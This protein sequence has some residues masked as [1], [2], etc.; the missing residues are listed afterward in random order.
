MIID[1]TIFYDF[2]QRIINAV[3]TASTQM[4]TWLNMTTD[5]FASNFSIPLLQWLFSLP[6]LI[7][8]VKYMKMYEFIIWALFILVLVKGFVKALLSWS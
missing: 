4:F 8:G 2:C 5:Q 1:F 3:L 6:G 7:P